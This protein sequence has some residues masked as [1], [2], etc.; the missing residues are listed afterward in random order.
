MPESITL[1]QYQYSPELVAQHPLPERDASRLMV[2]DRAGQSWEHRCVTHL[3]DFL[4]EGDLLVLND[5]KVFPARLLSMAQNV[6]VLLLPSADDSRLTTDN[7]PC[8]LKPGRKI[9][10]GMTIQFAPDFSGKI[11]GE[12]NGFFE[13]ALAGSDI[14]GAIEKYGLPP[15]P[16]YIRRKTKADYTPEDR[17]RYQSVF[18]AKTGSAAAPTASLHFS[19]A[20]LEKIKARGV[21]IAFVT[22]HVSTDTF[23]P[24]RAQNIAEH[25]MHGERFFIPEETRQKIAAAKKEGRRVIAVGTTV[26]RALESDWSRA[27]TY[28]YITPGFPFKI[29]GGLL[30]N[31]HQPESTLIVLVSAFAGREFLMQAYAEAIKQRYRLFSYGDC[32]LI[33]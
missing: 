10:E 23:L 28:L 13:I 25:V 4:R 7:Y 6:E 33:L 32:M 16:P 17:E 11:V 5:T 3:P 14:P 19:E 9:K 26:V 18:A 22:L 31:F 24:I 8:L 30:T 20:L 1:F 27:A 29:A 21:E 15:L 2:V 12:A